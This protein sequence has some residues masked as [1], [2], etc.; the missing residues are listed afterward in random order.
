MKGGTA[1]RSSDLLA[2]LKQRQENA[3]A[4]ARSST[5][6]VA[7]TSRSGPEVKLVI[8]NVIEACRSIYEARPC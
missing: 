8:E 5:V 1:P 2:H 3:A 4:A 6:A 7:E